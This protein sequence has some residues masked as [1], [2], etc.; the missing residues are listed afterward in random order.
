MEQGDGHISGNSLVANGQATTREEWHDRT[1][2][3]THMEA[4][5]RYIPYFTGEDDAENKDYLELVRTS[6]SLSKFNKKGQRMLEDGWTVK[7]KK[8]ALRTTKE[9]LSGIRNHLRTQYM[10][11]S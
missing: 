5:T 2:G 7:M 11:K 3:K 1:E 8:K 9:R 6:M 4:A 10:C